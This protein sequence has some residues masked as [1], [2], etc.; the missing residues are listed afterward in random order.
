[1]KGLDNKLIHEFK[2]NEYMFLRMYLSLDE[3]MEIILSYIDLGKIKIKNNRVTKL[4]LCNTNLQSFPISILKL[5]L[6]ENLDLTNNNIKELPNNI[7]N[8]NNLR[9]LR[10]KDNNLQTLPDSLCDLKRLESLWL[11]KNKL[12]SLPKNLGNLTQLKIRLFIYLPTAYYC[13]NDTF[14]GDL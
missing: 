5:K 11:E 1:M 12:K 6:L 4:N 3:N 13:A 8:L 2:I 14:H 7:D 10:L 9:E